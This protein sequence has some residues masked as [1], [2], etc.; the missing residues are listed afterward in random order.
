MHKDVVNYLESE[1]ITIIHQ[2]VN[3]SD[4]APRHFGLFDLIKQNPSDQDSSKSL[5]PAISKIIH[6]ID[7]KDYKKKL[8][9]NS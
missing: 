2:P 9:I 1:G 6:S 5:N 3:S 7:K 4:L 8:S